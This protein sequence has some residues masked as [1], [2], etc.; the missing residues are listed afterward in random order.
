MLVTANNHYCDA[1]PSG[2]LETL[3]HLD[4][5]HFMHIGTYRNSS[6]SR[7]IVTEVN[8]IKIGFLDFNQKS[9]NGKDAMFTESQQKEMLGKFF[10]SRVPGQIDAARKLGAEYIIVCIHYG[11]QNSVTLSEAQQSITQYL[12]D[13]GA[14]LIVGSHPHLLQQFGT[15]TAEDGRVVPVAYSMGNF[16][17]SMAELSL[18]KYNIIL[19]VELERQPDGAVIA[20]MTYI[21]CCILPET[22]EGSYIITPTWKTKGLTETQIEELAEAQK[23]IITIMG[24]DISP[25]LSD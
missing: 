19:N 14:D 18:N 8:G 16:C 1:G 10:R 12:A 23:D 6:E 22:S 13:C 4:E 3:D 24:N 15:V 17:S 25:V 11:T 5:Y 21:P 2:L 7:V 9:T 20:G